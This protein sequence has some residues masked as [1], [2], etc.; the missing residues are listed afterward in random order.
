MAQT[1]S[2][3]PARNEPE[4]RARASV[5]AVSLG[6]PFWFNLLR[7]ASALRPA[8]ATKVDVAS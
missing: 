6:A 7:T 3:E 8:L 4:E 5:L 2:P 1:L